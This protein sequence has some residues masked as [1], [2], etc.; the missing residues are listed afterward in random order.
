MA[1]SGEKPRAID[2]PPASLPILEL[3]WR[4]HWYEQRPGMA[5]AHRVFVYELP[6]LTPVE[7]LASLLVIYARR[8]C[9]NSGRWLIWRRWNRISR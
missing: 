2:S 7:A 1:T 3:H 4:L 9:R 5:A 8:F 6:R